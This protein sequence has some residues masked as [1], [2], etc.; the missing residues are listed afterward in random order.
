MI[1]LCCIYENDHVFCQSHA[2][3]VSLFNC[4]C[5]CVCVWVWILL[6]AAKDN[7]SVWSNKC[8]SHFWAFS[9]PPLLNSVSIGGQISLMKSRGSHFTFRRIS[10]LLLISRSVCSPGWCL[11]ARRGRRQGLCFGILKTST[12][13][14]ILCIRS[15]QCKPYSESLIVTLLFL[16]TLIP[17][18]LTS[19][20]WL[21]QLALRDQTNMC[22]QPL[23]I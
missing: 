20:L 23:P 16:V 2:V 6:W 22:H 10:A 13:E 8:S 18:W 11:V 21:F 4:V 7:C 15:A 17:W 3:F 1:V 9:S 14:V 12:V 5:I 19:D